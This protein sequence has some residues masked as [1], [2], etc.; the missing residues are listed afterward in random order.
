MPK[1]TPTSAPVLY[2]KDGAYRYAKTPTQ[3]TQLRYEGWVV[4]D[5]PM[6]TP[7]SAFKAGPPEGK[8]GPADDKTE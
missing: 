6:P 8:H 3:A 4:S 5:Q 1:K 7:K 2:T